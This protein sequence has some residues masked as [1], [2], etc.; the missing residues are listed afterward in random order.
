METISRDPHPRVVIAALYHFAPLARYRALRQPLLD[1]CKEVDLRGTLLL[2]PE[3]ING[4]VAGS[5]ASIDKLLRFIREQP[6]LAD[7]EHKESYASF[8]P[9]LRM[10]VLFKKEIVALG[11][12]ELLPFEKTGA[13]VSSQEWNQLIADS[14]C[15][16]IDTRN[17]FECELGT[18]ENAI[19]PGTESFGE[20]P[21][22]VERHLD[23]KKHKKVAMFCTGGIRCEKASAYLLAQG[24]EEV[25]QLKG[26]ILK[27]LEETSPEQSKWNGE[28]FVFDGRVTVDQSL[29]RG[30]YELCYGCR[31][32]VS[33]EDQKSPLYEE[34][35]SCPRCAPSLAE[36]KRK[37][38]EE[39][40]R[41]IRLAKDR[42]SKHMGQELR[43]GRR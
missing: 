11:H 13:Y 19:V 41:Q 35:V 33:T 30:S 31:F 3:G 22:F 24:F 42:G 4:T 43:R 28:C 21:E 9:F 6:E 37:G 25:Y 10:K 29:E 8:V 40:Q 12:P 1:L 18:F 17:T 5:R 7:L 2:A 36:E 27:Y 32:P 15:T 23:P 26:G 34:G 39:R 14:E 20:F 38:L 16:V